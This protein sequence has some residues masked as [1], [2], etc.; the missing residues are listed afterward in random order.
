MR[1]L[2]GKVTGGFVASLI[3]GS[4]GTT[5]KPGHAEARAP[6]TLP[7]VDCN[8][9]TAAFRG[10]AVVPGG[11]P[12]RRARS[13]RTSQPPAETPAASQNDTRFPKPYTPRPAIPPFPSEFALFVLGT[14]HASVIPQPRRW[15]LALKK[16]PVAAEEKIGHYVLARNTGPRSRT[17]PKEPADSCPPTAPQAPPLPH[18]RSQPGQGAMPPAA[19]CRPSR[20]PLPVSPPMSSDIKVYQ[21]ISRYI[22]LFFLFPQPPPAPAL[23]SCYQ[24]STINHQLPNEHSL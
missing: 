2:R 13:Q 14:P 24:P 9:L 18:P 5:A 23:G 20:L 16:P 6:A 21:G 4:A 3:R 12:G 10:S 11:A 8:A 19:P 15:R 7:W 17:P 1:F 22:K